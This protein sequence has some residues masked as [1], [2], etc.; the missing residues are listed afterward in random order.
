MIINNYRQLD[1]PHLISQLDPE[2][3]EGCSCFVVEADDSDGTVLVEITCGEYAG[4]RHWFPV[5]MVEFEDCE[6]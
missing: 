5:E 4:L 2:L 1:L 6:E 3:V